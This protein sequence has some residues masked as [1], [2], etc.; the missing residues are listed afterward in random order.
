VTAEK[1]VSLAVLEFVAQFGE[2]VYNDRIAVDTEALEWQAIE[3]STGRSRILSATPG[4]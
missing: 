3:P 2:T 4:G 1:E